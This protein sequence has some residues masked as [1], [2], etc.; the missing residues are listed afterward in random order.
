MGFRFK[1]GQQLL[2]L[3]HERKV[4]I[5]EAMM[6]REM[7]VRQIP[8]EQ[9]MD[10]MREIYTVMRESAERGLVS[11]EPSM[12]GLIGTSAV[13]MHKFYEAGKSHVSPFF[14]RA[15]AISLAVT[16]ENAR[17]GKIAACP[18]GGASGVVPGILLTLE[19]EL[20]IEEEKLHKA[21]LTAGA[22]G[23]L[24]AAHATLSGAEG[25]CQAEVGSG[26]AMAAAAMVEVLGGTP[27]QVLEAA[28]MAIK[29]I[30]GL[31]CDPV[32]GLVEVPCSKRN[33]GGVAVALA[34][35]EL[36]LAGVRS[37][38][39]FDEIVDTMK[40]VGAAMPGTL[41]ETATGGLAITKTARDFVASKFPGK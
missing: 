33:T 41:R 30:M 16:E 22:I 31:V 18:T 3:C 8:A 29:N 39:P 5:S 23:L 15:L 32:A 24:I 25:G 2:E 21:L 13:K 11:K 38:I 4:N 40:A 28:G 7:R 9:V 20:G 35:A 26:A 12:G 19:D 27:E 10:E 17:M 6:W 34:A 37:F 1:T 36:S 14:T